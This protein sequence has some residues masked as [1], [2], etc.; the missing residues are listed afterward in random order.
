MSTSHNSRKI[1]T[2]REAAAFRAKSSLLKLRR[3]YQDAFEM[4]VN[5]F[6][7]SSDS[8]REPVIAESKTLLWTESEPEERLLVAGKIQNLRLAVAAIDG[9]TVPAG[10]TY[11]FWKHV[12]R[13]SRLRGF[14]PG[15]EIREGCIIPTVGG[16]LCQ[17]SNSLYDAALKAN[18]AIVERH[19]HTQVI[20]GSLA[21]Q[22]RD[23]TVFWNYVDLRFRSSEPFTIEAKMDSEHLTV[24]FR[25]A[26]P[27]VKTLHQ[28]GRAITSNGRANS[29]A[30]CG[31]DD[32]FRAIKPDALND[33]SHS[34]YLV[35]EF[36]PE[37]D[38]HIQSRRS[39]KD[40][41]MMPI[42]GR[43]FR[44][45]NYAWNTGGFQTVVQ[46]RG[47]TAIRSYRSRKLAAQG[48]ARQQNLLSMYQ[49][50]SE[51]YARSL[52]FDVINIVVQ[53]NLLPFLWQSGHLGG[54]SFDV[55]MTAMPMEEI[56]RQLDIAHALHPESKT[57]GDFRADAGLLAA[58]TEA[59]AN[60]RRLITPHTAIAALFGERAELVDWKTPKPAVINRQPQ[61]KPC[62]VF[63]AS[64]VGRKGCY[65]LREALR[66]HD[67]Q[68]ITLG[69]NIEEPDFWT[70]FDVRQG[71]TNWLEHADLVV[72]PAFV[73]H[74]PRR[75]LTAAAAGIPV[76]ATKACGVENVNGIQS[77]EAGDADMLSEAIR[78]TVGSLQHR[79]RTQ[80]VFS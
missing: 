48:A 47:V 66:R 56:Q 17:L 67:V 30:T 46:S 45:A 70:G 65:E 36:V 78:S 51:S 13:A 1:P 49:R 10:E 21:E 7:K 75:L 54:R 24:R 72:L 25:G 35:D 58:E 80:K 33:L 11:S 9:V 32:C 6:S 2:R 73:E 8:T 14:V 19:S 18:F 43:H 62:I 41:L 74:R 61:P 60:A 20:P 12:G 15:R 39:E 29:C 4:K 27:T 53:Q 57:L 28:I 3:V 16:G 22:G 52:K 26:R 64:T 59:L 50:L 40:I 68:L 37:F 34:A 77:V 31:M 5:V 71:T 63:P 42:D 44:K 79:E 76:I 69:P 55:L 38:D 23:A